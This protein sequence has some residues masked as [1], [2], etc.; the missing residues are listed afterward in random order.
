MI[1]YNDACRQFYTWGLTNYFRWTLSRQAIGRRKERH[2]KTSSLAWKQSS[3]CSQQRW[4]RGCEY[5]CQ[6]NVWSDMTWQLGGPSVSRQTNDESTLLSH[7]RP[8]VTVF[9]DRLWRP[10]K[11]TVDAINRQNA[12]LRGFNICNN[13][14]IY[15][16][17]TIK[18]IPTKPKSKIWK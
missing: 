12:E 17:P 3:K 16:K 2:K 7:R 9:R 10:R 6:M 8:G 5:C 13:T 14:E 18:T 1:N 15:P 4:R 11:C